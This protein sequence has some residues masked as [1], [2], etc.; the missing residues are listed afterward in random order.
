M[1]K[2]QILNAIEFKDVSKT[3]GT[4]KANQH[5]SFRVKKG[6]IHALIGENGA[7]KSTLMSILFGLY[8]PDSGNIK[9]NDKD[10]IIKSPNDANDLG[11]GMVHQHFKLVN[12]YTNLENIV[13]GSE[14]YNPKTRI[15][16]YAPAIKKIKS[17][18]ETFNIH[19]DL[20]NITGNETVATQQKVEIMKMLYRDSDIL[21]FDEPTAVL[22]DEEIQGLLNTFKLFKQQ[23][24]TIIFI[25]HKL[26][27]IKE[28]ADTATVLRH[29]E[30]KGNFDVAD[31]SVEKMAE[32]MVGGEVQV[33]RNEYTDSSNNSTILSLKN[34]STSSSKPLKNLS[35]DVKA[36]EIVA[37]AGVEGN[38]QKDLE[39][40]ISGMMKPS[41]GSLLY[42]KTDRV[43]KSFKKINKSKKI[44][45][46]SLF[47]SLFILLAISATLFTIPRIIEKPD[48]KAIIYLFGISGA[49]LA[50]L[51]CILILKEYFYEWFRERY[52]NGRLII[53]QQVNNNK[54]L[55]LYNL[56]S[57]LELV[58][59]FSSIVLVIFTLMGDFPTYKLVA[60]IFA[61]ILPLVY[62]NTLTFIR[63]KIYANVISTLNTKQKIKNL[64]PNLASYFIAISTVVVSVL[65]II[66]N[67]K[68]LTY[69]LLIFLTTLF[70]YMVFYK[71]IKPIIFAKITSLNQESDFIDL[72]S[73]TVKEI[74]KMGLS[75][76]PSDRHKHGLALDYTIS[77]NTVLRRMWDKKYQFLSIFK[78]KTIKRETLDIIDNFDVRGAREGSSL[79]RSLSGGNQ[80]K[81][82]V[83]REMSSPHDF[84][85]I[86]QPTRGLDVG[87]IKNIHQKIIQEKKDGKAILLISYELDEVF[88]LADR[89][90]VINGGEIVAIK[91]ADNITRKEIGVYMASKKQEVIS[92]I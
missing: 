2:S 25:S 82:I 14:F 61:I 3:F 56:V 10:V 9:V 50:F 44:F 85:L 30:V 64:L 46:I 20:N 65:F 91:T 18:Q 60:G 71:I 19:F 52:M 43:V 57:N 83:G 6:D 37:I 28:V 63:E 53:M 90:A 70:L 69:I 38:G 62:I 51:S 47:L 12:V 35:L 23:G 39:Y 21:I 58:S 72:N 49:V 78:N 4:I 80:Q 74:S 29:G 1:E 48:I 67:D 36:G 68:T 15:I 24:K 5:I 59:I 41:S 17:I 76:I 73:L 33:I 16:D 13:M 81:F 42:R 87:A 45:R 26:L 88:A 66:F 8:E 84:I 54:K 31:V 92:D 7:G 79:A 77:Q 11:I 40:V 86:L 27:E 34:V 32:L 75:Y 89:I 22:T 55:K